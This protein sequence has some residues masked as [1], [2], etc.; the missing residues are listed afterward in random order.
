MCRWTGVGWWS[1]CGCGV[2]CVPRAAA[3]TP[4]RAGAR[5]TGPI[6]AAYGPFDQVSQGRGQ[7]V[8]GPSR[9]TPAGGT[10]GEPVTAHG[11]AR[12]AAHSSARRP[13]APRDWR[14]A[15]RAASTSCKDINQGRADAG[16]RHISPRRLARMLLTRHLKAEQYELPA[17]LTAARPETTHLEV[18]IRDFAA[19]LAPHADNAGAH[20]RAGSP[21][22]EQPTCPTCTPSPAAWSETVT[23]CSPPSRCYTATAP[24][25]ASIP[26][27]SG[28]PARSTAERASPSWP[29]HPP[30]ITP[31]PVTTECETEPNFLQS[32]ILPARPTGQ[33]SSNVTRS[34]TRPNQGC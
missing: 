11:S 6:P 29:R 22:S 7:G 19:L 14:L 26:R 24:P 27:P 8:S 20:S 2:W 23:P 5:R 12:A 1:V 32:H 3:D 15:S 25:R 21:R 18:S 31:P 30:R 16:R 9:G 28:S 33:A 13:G 17:K 34:C 10:R 4:P